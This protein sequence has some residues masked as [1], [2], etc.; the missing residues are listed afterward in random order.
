MFPSTVVNVVWA[1][2]EA[3]YET[4]VDRVPNAEVIVDVSV[5]TLVEVSMELFV[6]VILEAF[7]DG[8][9]D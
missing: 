3:E 4:E 6:E 5:K 8:A 2:A 9:G 1:D 7:E